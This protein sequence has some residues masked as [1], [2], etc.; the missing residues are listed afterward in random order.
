MKRSLYGYFMYMD[1]LCLRMGYGYG[2]V[3][4][5]DKICIWFALYMT[6]LCIRK[7]YVYGCVMHMDVSCMWMCGFSFWM[8]PVPSRPSPPASRSQHTHIHN[9]SIS[10]TA[11]ARTAFLGFG[12]QTW[13][14]HSTH[15]PTNTSFPI[16][17]IFLR[18][19]KSAPGDANPSPDP[20]EI[21]QKHQKSL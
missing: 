1:V 13:N 6:V 4:Y 3:M 9:T 5:M 15:L 21:L 2:C 10:A 8:H 19:L 11:L 18:G 12:R 17:Q 7:C 14:L 20:S 16:E